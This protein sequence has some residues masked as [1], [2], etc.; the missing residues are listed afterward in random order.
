M[1]HCVMSTGDAAFYVVSSDVCCVC[2]RTSDAASV[3]VYRD[4]TCDV[5]RFV[6]VVLGLS[7]VGASFTSRRAASGD[8]HNNVKCDGTSQRDA[9]SMKRGQRQTPGVVG[10]DVRFT[11]DASANALLPQRRSAHWRAE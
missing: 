3:D 1:R 8:V 4:A 11:L 5:P 6:E 10:L 9:L 7:H 2:A